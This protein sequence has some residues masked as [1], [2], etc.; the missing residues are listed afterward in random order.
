MKEFKDS[1][2]LQKNQIEEL[3][4][5]VKILEGDLEAAEDEAETNK[6]YVTCCP[7]GV[8]E[9]FKAVNLSTQEDN[10]VGEYTDHTNQ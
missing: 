9:P 6:A 2:E 5:K 10:R 1:T 8:G 4:R 7:K 3:E